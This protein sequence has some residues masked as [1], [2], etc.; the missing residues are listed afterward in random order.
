MSELIY[1]SL[2]LLYV[3]MGIGVNDL[4]RRAGVKDVAVTINVLLWPI[5][6]IVTSF[7][8]GE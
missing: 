5:A 7:N 2:T 6:L 1:V 3:V 4:A 8:R